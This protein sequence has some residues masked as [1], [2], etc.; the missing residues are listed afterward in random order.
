M[1]PGEF[2]ISLTVKDIGASMEFY[3]KPGFEKFGG[4]ISQN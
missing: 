2:L 3:E 4:D 1:K